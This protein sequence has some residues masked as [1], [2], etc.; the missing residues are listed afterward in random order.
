MTREGAI[1]KA[2][3]CNWTITELVGQSHDFYVVT[4]LWREG[5]TQS[6][7]QGGFWGETG[8]SL[9]TARGK[10][11]F[12]FRLEVLKKIFHKVRLSCL[13]VSRAKTLR[14][15]VLMLQS[16]VT[17]KGHRGTSWTSGSSKC[18]RSQGSKSQGGT[19]GAQG[20][21]GEG[22]H[23]SGLYYLWRLCRFLLH[24]KRET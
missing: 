7:M 21:V 9:K 11:C 2:V 24:F 12:F 16:L 6:V 17:W 14:S 18:R 20:I 22:P 3:H 15:A 19:V 4:S 5:D 10:N 1:R 23:Y 8:G 13:V